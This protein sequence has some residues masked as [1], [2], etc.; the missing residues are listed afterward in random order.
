MDY[1]VS[2]RP[3]WTTKQNPDS[4]KKKKKKKPT[5]DKQVTGK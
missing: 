2:S 4:E 1:I 5:E 3:A